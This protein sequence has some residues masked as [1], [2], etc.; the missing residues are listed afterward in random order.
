MRSDDLL[1]ET[2]ENIDLE[3]ET[4]PGASPEMEPLLSA[5]RWVVAARPALEP[6]PGFVRASR[7]RLQARTG[8]RYTHNPWMIWTRSAIY[9]WQSP[10]LHVAMVVL[11]A[12][13]LYFNAVSFLQASRYWLPGDTLY[14]L[15]PVVEN[16]RLLASFSPE[17]DAALHIEY[18][19]RRLIEV[20]S[21]V[22]ENRF[23]EIPGAVANFDYHVSRAVTL[24][25]QVA[26]YEQSHARGL[27]VSLEDT[28]SGQMSMVT[29]LAGFTPDASQADFERLLIISTGG[30][31]DMQ[32]FLLP[33]S[34]ETQQRG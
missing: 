20:Q 11:L 29:L 10:P 8:P 24:V 21:L 3:A 34:G 12:A 15:K 5:A 26:G 18:A 4:P 6:R 32:E 17:R 1:Q 14:P 25:N 19:H 33:D 28:L 2:L 9:W 31:L 16:V 23:E 27:A 13:A 22:L 30:V 7:R